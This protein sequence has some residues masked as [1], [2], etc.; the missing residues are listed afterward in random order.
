MNKD[1][2]LLKE[3]KSIVFKTVGIIG[4]LKDALKNLENIQFAFIY[5]SYAKAKE[6]YLSDVDLAIIGAPNEDEVIKKF[7]NLE[8]K[9]K[10][11]INYKLYTLAEFK[12]NIAEKEPFI[13]QVLNDKKIMVIGDENELR[14]ISKR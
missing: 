12:K 6:N 2:P 14:K 1:Y 5:G 9:L 7:D 10:R 8:E 4:S 11:E 13:R 3:L